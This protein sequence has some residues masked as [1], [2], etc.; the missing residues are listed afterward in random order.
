MAGE[1]PRPD[2]EL[3]TIHAAI[4]GERGAFDAL[5]RAYASRL[6]WLIQL[7][8]DPALRAR[9]SVDDVMQ[10][11]LLVVSDRVRSLVVDGEGAFW[12]WLCKVVEQR[13]I[14]A[15]RR[16]L[17]AAVR[18]VRRERK[19]E[20]PAHQTTHI[21]LAGVLMDPGTSPSGRLKHAEQREAVHAALAALPPSYREVIALR[22]LEGLSVPETAEIMGRSHGAVSVLL[23]KAIKRLAGVLAAARRGEAP[24]A[25][26]DEPQDAEDP[27]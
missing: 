10:D 4:A 17:Q 6:R 26:P 21:G 25:G 19:L 18:D 7:R 16:H 22:V 9:V 23:N 24:R 12:S 13:L 2:G 3:P 27:A 15:R 11:V 5:V 20:A 1:R 14:D 8:L